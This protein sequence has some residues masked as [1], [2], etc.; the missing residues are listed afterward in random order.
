M[1]ARESQSASSLYSSAR[2]ALSLPCMYIY[3]SVTRIISYLYYSAA[4]RVYRHARRAFLFPPFA[5]VLAQ[6]SCP[7]AILHDRR[8][9]SCSPGEKIIATSLPMTPIGGEPPPRSYS[10]PISASMTFRLYIKRA[11]G[12]F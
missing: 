3:E 8:D 7:R 9:R 11:R 1:G 2:C 12:I 5:C 4:R 6:E 10:G